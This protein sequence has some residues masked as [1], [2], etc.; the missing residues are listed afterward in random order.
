MLGKL[1]KHDFKDLS[2][3][4]MPLLLGFVGISV[5]FLLFFSIMI[6]SVSTITAVLGVVSTVAYII[7]LASV[8]L[9]AVWILIYFFYRITVSDEGYLAMT[10]PVKASEHIGALVIAGAA[11]MAITFIIYALSLAGVFLLSSRTLDLNLSWNDIK[12][13]M[14]YAGLSLGNEF[15]IGVPFIIVTALRLL[16]Y[17]FTCGLL[18]FLAI[19]LGQMMKQHKIFF[20]VL[21]YI[22]VN[23]VVSSVTALILNQT[24]S[25]TVTLQMAINL[26]ITIILS[27]IYFL[28]TD[29]I[30]EN[31]LNL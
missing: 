28:V 31:K 25:L 23:M 19:A 20:S 14:N 4:Y 29:Y 6:R 21:F 17:L 3:Y 18:P 26:A 16:V 30:L 15:E 9:I 24:T 5:I 8:A 2:A 10:L 27:I 7:G 11:W 22:I 12:L 13:Y 1:I